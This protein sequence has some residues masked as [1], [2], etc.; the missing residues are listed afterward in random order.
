[1]RGA[2]L[3]TYLTFLKEQLRTPGNTYIQTSAR[4]LQM[5]MRIDEYRVAFA[6][7]DGVNTIVSVLSG[8][9]N[10]QL[11]YQLT[12]CL[13]CM[14][15]NEQVASRMARYGIIPVL[16]DVLTESTKEKVQRIILAVFRNLLEKVEE[17]QIL[18]DNA[19]QM[20]QC[21]VL[22]TLELMGAR[23]Y[24]DTDLTEDIEFVAE[25]LHTN[26][27]DLSSFDEYCTELRSGRLIWSPVHKSEKFWRENAQ[28]FNEKGFELVK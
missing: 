19:L 24:D 11:Q 3:A 17:V 4:N 9:A 16:A 6:N 18:R 1:M 28:R 8:K 5:M 12:F 7:S 21:K 25:K 23:K 13:W 27:Q 20:V 14:S 10:F 22:K 15:F 2:D 26:V